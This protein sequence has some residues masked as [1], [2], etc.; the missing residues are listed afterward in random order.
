MAQKMSG[1]HMASWI[2]CTIAAVQLGLVGAFNYDLLGMLGGLTRW[3][4]ILIGLGGLL[5]L[6]HMIMFMQGKK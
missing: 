2:L 3:V 6:W 5:S 1:I 4:Y